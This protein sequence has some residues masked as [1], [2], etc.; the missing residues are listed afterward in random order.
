MLGL[1]GWAQS[2]VSQ[3][4]SFPFKIP[5][6]TALRNLVGSALG[7]TL[8]ILEAR[9]AENLFQTLCFPF[10]IVLLLCLPVRPPGDGQRL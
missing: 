8:F 6:N 7:D 1:V 3:S 2:H 9:F 4:M 5:G 10:L